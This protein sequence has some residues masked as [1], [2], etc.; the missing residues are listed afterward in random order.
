MGR[1]RKRNSAAFGAN[2][3]LEAVKHDRTI[4]EP[5]MLNQVHPVQIS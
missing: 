3:A 4:A 2:V 1:I 5:A